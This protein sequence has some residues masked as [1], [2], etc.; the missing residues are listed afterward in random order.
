M[1]ANQEEERCEG[2]EG[3]LWNCLGR[4]RPPRPLKIRPDP[5]IL[6]ISSLRPEISD[7]GTGNSGLRP[8]NIRTAITKNLQKMKKEDMSGELNMFLDKRL[9]I[10]YVTGKGRGTL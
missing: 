3:G 4:R 10:G 1:E 6:D 7:V 2:R 8:G 5:F 9:G